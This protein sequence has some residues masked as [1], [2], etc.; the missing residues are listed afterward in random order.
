MPFLPQAIASFYCSDHLKQMQK[1]SLCSLNMAGK[2]PTYSAHL[3]FLLRLQAST[4]Y[5]VF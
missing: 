4:E 3:S 1:G 5:S 2:I